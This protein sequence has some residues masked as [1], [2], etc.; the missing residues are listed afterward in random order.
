MSPLTVGAAV[1]AVMAGPPLYGLVQ[2]GQLDGTSAIG[3][4]LVVAGACA[5]GASYVLNL[6][7]KY[8]KEEVRNAKHEALLTAMAEADAAAKR[9]ADAKA[10]AAKA[11]QNK[12]S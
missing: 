6:I 3:R 11:A 12:S 10:A 4:G 2:A 1:A 9:H 5:F 8:E 7:G